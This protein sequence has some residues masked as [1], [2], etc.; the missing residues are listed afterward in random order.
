MA[1]HEIVG[2]G[3]G[4]AE[5]V[6]SLI[7]DGEG[8]SYLSL[9]AL[10]QMSLERF[11][12]LGR[13]SR[14]RI[15][16]NALASSPYFNMWGL[17]HLYWEDAAKALIAEGSSATQQLSTLLQGA[18]AAQHKVGIKMNVAEANVEKIVD[19]IPSLTAPT[20]ATL[21]P[22]KAL[23]GEKWF[24]VESIIAQDIVRE[25]IPVLI[26]NGAVGIIEYPLNK[27]I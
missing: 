9:L 19:L 21:Y 27:V 12:Q 25:L 14:I 4:A 5:E 6:R 20:V 22:T 3:P 16:V 8:A 13:Q 17:P 11:E 24:S 23:G 10:R 2:R 7:A 26:T 1:Y 15:L 18:L